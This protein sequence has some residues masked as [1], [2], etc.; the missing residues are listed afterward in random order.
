M[1]SS[2]VGRLTLIEK[3]CACGQKAAPNR[4]ICYKCRSVSIRAKNPIMDIYYALKRSAKKRNLEFSVTKEYF[5]PFI[6]NSGLLDNRGRG[7]EAFTIDR[8]KNSIGYT[9]D[10]IQILTKSQ[11]SAKYWELYRHLHDLPNMITPGEE[12]IVHPF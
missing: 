8:K 1:D 11:N 3:L 6:Q 10:N 5:I 12:I 2:V 7:A 9:N 4:S